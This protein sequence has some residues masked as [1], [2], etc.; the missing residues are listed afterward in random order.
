MHGRLTPPSDGAVLRIKVRPRLHDVLRL[1]V[2]DGHFAERPVAIRKDRIVAAVAGKES[3]MRT[4][5]DGGEIAVGD[6]VVGVEHAQDRLARARISRRINGVVVD[7]RMSVRERTVRR[8]REIGLRDLTAIPLRAR[9]L[10]VQRA[11][12]SHRQ[13]LRAEVVEVS[14]LRVNEERSF[15]ARIQL[16]GDRGAG[17]DVAAH[18][19]RAGRILS[20]PH[21]VAAQREEQPSGARGAETID[22]VRLIDRD[23]IRLHGAR[24]LLRMYVDR[25][26]Q[27]TDSQNEGV[28]SA[29]FAP[30]RTADHQWMP[31]TKS[32]SRLLR[33]ECMERDISL[34]F[35]R[36]NFPGCFVECSVAHVAAK[37]TKSPG[38]L[39]RAIRKD[40]HKVCECGHKNGHSISS[41]GSGSAVPLRMR[42]RRMSEGLRKPTMRGARADSTTGQRS[43]PRKC[44]CCTVSVMRSSAH[45]TTFGS[46]AIVMIDSPPCSAT[47]LS[48][49]LRDAMPASV[50]S[51]PAIG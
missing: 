50:P 40:D 18:A 31:W 48:I 23:D 11:E 3:V 39:N 19:C 29:Q 25:G 38:H 13:L 4:G 6:V 1:V 15:R 35:R 45:A 17:R 51:S 43:T 37:E 47:A 2:V 28:T 32:L 8:H 44:I 42:M 12:E 9:R 49:A 24:A 14:R 30:P 36:E 33:E 46:S 7:L 26:E 10:D 41:N 5:D 20:D 16:V 22:E 21:A 27:K 34:P